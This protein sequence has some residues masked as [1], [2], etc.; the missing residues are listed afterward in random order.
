MSPPLRNPVYPVF[1]CPWT[2]PENWFPIISPKSHILVVNHV[3]S[4]HP[5]FFRGEL[6]QFQ[7]YLPSGHRHL[8]TFFRASTF[9]GIWQTSNFSFWSRFKLRISNST[10]NW[11]IHPN[12]IKALFS[13]PCAA[14]ICFFMS[15]YRLAVG[16]T[17]PVPTRN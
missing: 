15:F 13:S 3:S 11:H 4:N 14:K 6:L 12:K 9:F 5:N 1:P 2:M 7:N 17:P 8:R 10:E 16:V